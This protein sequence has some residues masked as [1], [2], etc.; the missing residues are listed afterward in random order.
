MIVR[1]V[2]PFQ[3]EFGSCST[4]V[5]GRCP[6]GYPHFYKVPQWSAFEYLTVLQALMALSSVWRKICLW[7]PAHATEPGLGRFAAQLL[8]GNMR[9][10]V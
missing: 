4:R 10:R 7:F 6:H 3:G 1:S 9:R 2:V 8:G 5:P